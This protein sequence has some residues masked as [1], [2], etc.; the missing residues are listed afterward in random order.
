MKP[1]TN[2]WT[3]FKWKWY[4]IVFFFLFLFTLIFEILFD[5]NNWQHYFETNQVL[6]RFVLAGI[7]AFITRILQEKQ[8][9][10]KRNQKT[11]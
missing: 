7:I 10:K 4:F 9:L 3:E 1:E 2:F 11:T 6:R 8:E 5:A